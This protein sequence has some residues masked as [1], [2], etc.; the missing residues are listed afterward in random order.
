MEENTFNSLWKIFYKNAKIIEKKYSKYISFQDTKKDSL[1][2]HYD[3][4]RIYFKNQYFQNDTNIDK[5]KIASCFVCAVLEVQPFQFE[6]SNKN[7][8][9]SIEFYVMNEIWGF[10]CGL[11]IIKHFIGDRFKKENKPQKYIQDCITKKWHFPE[12]TD[13]QKDKYFTCLLRDLHRWRINKREKRFFNLL[14]LL[15][16]LFF[17]ME[18]YHL[19]IFDK[20]Y[21]EKNNK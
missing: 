21:L 1:I 15:S 2:K 4:Y 7:D 18:Q 10:I 8:K 13:S 9:F 20:L 5:H 11:D 17:F 3:E 16:H 14:P 19:E 6:E 12:T